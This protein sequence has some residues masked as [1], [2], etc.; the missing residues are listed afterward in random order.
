MP[1]GWQPRE[2]AESAVRSAH[3]TYPR[4]AM[5]FAPQRARR[6]CV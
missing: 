1:L 2:R 3:E 5:Q 4:A 6:S